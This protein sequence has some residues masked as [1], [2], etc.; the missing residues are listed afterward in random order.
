MEPPSIISVDKNTVEAYVVDEVKWESLYLRVLS[1]LNLDDY[2]L[3]FEFLSSEEMQR[4]NFEY[5][6]MDKPTDVLS[7]PQM[8]FSVPH[9]LGDTLNTDSFHKVLGD[10]AICLELCEQNAAAIGHSI[11]RECCFLLIHGILH[12]CGHDHL[13]SA[14]ETVM[15]AQQNL[16]LNELTAKDWEGLIEV[17]PI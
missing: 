13:T 7:F 16:I 17:R 4:L 2:Q 9:R 15:V 5:R 3:S 14:E 10:I 12:L 8:E 6:H 11:G 1:L